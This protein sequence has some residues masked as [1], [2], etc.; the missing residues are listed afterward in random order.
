[1]SHFDPVVWNK[2]WFIDWKEGMSEL[3]SKESTIV[4]PS[5]YE[6]MDRWFVF[7]SVSLS[8]QMRACIHTFNLV[9][10]TPPTHCRSV[11]NTHTQYPWSLSSGASPH[12]AISAHYVSFVSLP[13]CQEWW[14]G[15]P[16]VPG[17]VCLSN[18]SSGLSK[19]TL[20]WHWTLWHLT[21][22]KRGNTKGALSKDHNAAP[23]NG[24][25]TFPEQP[26]IEG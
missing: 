23:R 22:K 4:C 10:G 24:V 1:M 8:N 2:V 25:L 15:A 21:K 16:I 7:P 17:A 6:L 26:V 5:P 18:R 12:N 14:A 9:Y 13:Y 19:C 3:C 20:P 11:S